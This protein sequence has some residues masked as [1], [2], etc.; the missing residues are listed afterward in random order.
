MDHEVLVAAVAAISAA[1]LLIIG[2]TSLTVQPAASLVT[3]F[4]G[5]HTV[6]LNGDPTP[7]DHQADLIITD[8]IGGVMSRIQELL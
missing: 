6:L 1:D 3:Y 8:R 2:G 4:H 5:R 7:Y